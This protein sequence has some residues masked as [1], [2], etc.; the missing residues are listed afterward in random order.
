[1]KK[2]TPVLLI[3]LSAITFAQE[4]YKIPFASKDN[5]IE[6][7]VV[8]KSA[9]TVNYVN[10]KAVNLPE[11]IKVDKANKT[12]EELKPDEEAVV[13]FTFNVEKEA[14]INKETK[15][16][17]EIISKSGEVWNKEITISVLPPEK[18]ELSELSKSI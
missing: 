7:A 12:I 18:F 2:K 11:W 15:L 13:S 17:F 16:S 1:M 14:K 3:L 10:V 9:E 4:V 8:N 5:S 6:L